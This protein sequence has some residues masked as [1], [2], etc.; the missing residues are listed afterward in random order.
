MLY[1]NHDLPC[2]M[3]RKLWSE[4]FHSSDANRQYVHVYIWDS[5]RENCHIYK[6]YKNALRLNHNFC[7]LTAIF[8]TPFLCE[9]VDF[10]LSTSSVLV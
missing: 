4:F 2:N 5:S 7:T 8:S 3:M 10:M 1:I 6:S 9:K